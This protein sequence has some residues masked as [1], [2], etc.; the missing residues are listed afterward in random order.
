MQGLSSQLITK[1]A[2]GKTPDAALVL[3]KGE[4]NSENQL[5]DSKENSDV[6]N[7]F[8]KLLEGLSGAENNVSQSL[9]N[10]SLDGEKLTI[11]SLLKNNKKGDEKQNSDLL[12]NKQDSLSITDPA[13]LMMFSPNVELNNEILSQ[14]KSSETLADIT[15]NKSRND[16]DELIKSLKGTESSKV[17]KVSKVSKD[18]QGEE[19]KIDNQ[20]QVLNAKTDNVKSLELK[21]KNL[22]S[23]ILNVEKPDDLSNAPDLEKSSNGK[24]TN[25][26]KIMMTGDDYLKNIEL[27]EKKDTDKVALV[28]TIDA[29]KNKS[30]KGYG[31]IQILNSEPLVKSSKEITLKNAE[32]DKPLMLDEVRTAEVKESNAPADIKHDV[33]LTL[34]SRDDRSSKT[35]TQSHES[36]KVLDLG[37][38]NTANTTEIIKKISDYVE[39]NNVANKINLD[40]T[41]KHESLGE[42]KIQ[43]S[44]MP[45]QS[46]NQSSNLIDMQITTSSKE[47]QDF[48]VKNEVSLIK[49][50][51][52]AGINLSDFR[53]VS[54]MSNTLDFGHSD[55]K[56]SN[57]QN[58]NDS[59]SR[60][61]M[62]FE[63]ENSSHDSAN[64]KDKRKNLWEE[65]Q[66]RHGA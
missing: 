56:N 20:P 57:S 66:Q 50:L 21:D 29:Q 28:N 44:K 6:E 4:V 37:K 14:D 26:Q 32:K 17:S 31:Q 5:D 47:G 23:F 10:Q 36:Q 58:N 1:S 9:K 41:V 7:N 53:V 12:M 2:N 19:G 46:T 54:S 52:N 60:Q 18:E 59:N 30:I 65:Y 55:S 13:I 42:F 16:L 25:S 61:F 39:Q 51:N 63:S 40:L 3:A 48:F 34:Q 45:S 33:V 38:L 24:S 27:S 11:C 62:S 8:L 15:I 35:E 22:L 49:N 43:V 64:G